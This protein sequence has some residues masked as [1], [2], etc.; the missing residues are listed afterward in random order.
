MR[1]STSHGNV[2]VVNVGVL[3]VGIALL[4]SW[5]SLIFLPVVLDRYSPEL[6]AVSIAVT[7]GI[8]IAIT[9]VTWRLVQRQPLSRP[10]WPWV[11]FAVLVLSSVVVLPAYWYLV[12]NGML[13]GLE[14]WEG[15][16]VMRLT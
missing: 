3:L 8:G 5:S 11:A 7:V 12:R 4:W 14:A 15:T 6:W 13:G 1:P 10:Q 16:V 2:S 9:Y